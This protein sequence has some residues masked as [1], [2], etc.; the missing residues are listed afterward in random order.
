MSVKIINQLEIKLA[1]YQ[2]LIEYQFKHKNIF[3]H[4]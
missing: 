2:F 4:N 3:M 1:I